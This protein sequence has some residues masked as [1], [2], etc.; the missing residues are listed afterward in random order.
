MNTNVM[1]L[2]VAVV[3]VVAVIVSFSS[4]R[5]FPYV[6]AGPLLSNA[7]RTF[8]TSLLLAVDRADLVM[9]KVRVADLIKIKDGVR[10]E[11]QS[12]RWWKAFAQISQKHVDYAVVDRQTFETRYVVELD[13]ASHR[14]AK[15]AE[16]DDIKNKA[17]AA[18]GI[19]VVRVK[20]ARAYDVPALTQ[21]IAAALA[22]PST[23][24]PKK[25]V[26]G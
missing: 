3:V 6:K 2:V 12:S 18:A 4:A 24:R 1:L 22:P 16:N 13:D 15:A 11:G 17:F 20:A 5:S 26:Q 9:V 25:A 21:L 7:E 8:F 19:P 23:A 14:G 10:K